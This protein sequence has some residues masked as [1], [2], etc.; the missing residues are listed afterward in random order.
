MITRRL[1]LDDI[2]E[3]GFKELIKPNNHIKILATPRRG[4]VKP[5]IVI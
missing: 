2:V 3:K 4:V 5:E 1:D